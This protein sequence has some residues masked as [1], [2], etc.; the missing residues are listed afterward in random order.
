MWFYVA[1]VTIW[2]PQWD[3]LFVGQLL[4]ACE[5]ESVDFERRIQALAER[6]SETT[7]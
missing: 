1:R 2:H 6:A 7:T 5:A 4:V 3:T